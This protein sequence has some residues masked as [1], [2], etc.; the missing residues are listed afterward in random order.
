MNKYKFSTSKY[1]FM[2]FRNKK[3]VAYTDE[4]RLVS[5]YMRYRNKL[6]YQVRIYK[7]KDLPYQIKEKIE[8]G[9]WDKELVLVGSYGQ[10]CMSISD[11]I[12]FIDHL[13]QFLFAMS[14]ITQQM[15]QMMSAMKLSSHE[16]QKIDKLFKN[17]KRFIHEISD[18]EVSTEEIFSYEVFE[19]YLIKLGVI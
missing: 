19:K 2:I 12:K 11:E 13:D 4:E 10:C 14:P 5:M 15:E 9:S 18:L 1:Y 7:F 17:L 6:H 16:K 3:I 8:E